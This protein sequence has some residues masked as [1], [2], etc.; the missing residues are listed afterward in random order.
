MLNMENDLPGD[1]ALFFPEDGSMVTD[2]TPT[3]M[4]EEPDDQDDAIASF[5]NQI[6]SLGVNSQSQNRE[7]THY[8][9]K[10]IMQ[11]A[12]TVNSRSIEGYDVFISPNILFTDIEPVHVDSNSYTI[13]TNLIEDLEYY[14]KV[15]AI[16]DDGGQTESEVFSFW[17]N[18][19]NSPP[20]EITLL[21]PERESI[22]GTRPLFSWSESSD[23]DLNDDVNYTFVYGDDVTSLVYVEV[24]DQL[25]HF[26]SDSLL[27]NTE[28]FWQ[29]IAED[30]S[31]A[32]YT[33]PLQSFFVNAENDNPE[34]FALL[35]PDS[36]SVVQ[37]FDQYLIWLPSTDLDGDTVEYE[38]FIDNQSIGVTNHNYMEVRDLMD[39]VTY[40]W[41]VIASDGIGGVATSATWFFTVNAEN[42]PPSEFSL[43]LPSDEALFTSTGITFN[44]QRS[45]DVDIYDSVAYSL[46]IQSEDTNMVIETGDTSLFIEDF[47]DNQIYHWSVVAYDLNSG[48]TN[49]TGGSRMFI[50]N[51]MNDTPSIVGLMAPN[52]GSTQSD[53]TPNFAWTNSYDPD[54]LDAVSYNLSWWEPFSTDIQSVQ[55]DS[56]G[57]TPNGYLMDNAI[58]QWRIKSEDLSGA[59]SFSDTAYFYTDAYA[60]PPVN[61]ST[62]APAPDA[63]MSSTVVNF[64]WFST[65]DP[66]PNEL[67]KYRIA[68]ST[69][70]SDTSAYVYTAEIEDTSMSI[71]LNNNLQYFW[72]AQA[73]DKDNFVVSS[74]YNTPNTFIIGTLST[75]EDL[76]PNV[77]ALHQNFPNP[78]NPTTTIRYDLPNEE[79]VSIVIFDVVGRKIRSLINQ[80]QSAG[81][82]R[83]QWDA[84]NDLG[85]PVSA[86]MY[87]Y[88]LHAGDHRSVKKMVLL[89]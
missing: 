53:L 40:E 23:D 3:L 71:L 17:T 30:Y 41:Y 10:V 70:W 59:A 7:K 44:W 58:Y 78:F 81:Y 48:T 46:H 61:F 14:W 86:G 27:D 75:E 89:K 66:D 36:G 20:A 49:N 85:E 68:Y 38:V 12:A 83:I 24:D 52:E 87:I 74:N 56:N 18:N 22:T 67:I 28:Y 79:D 26:T 13:D 60:E 54:P 19:Q 1:F 21:T 69:D 32:T 42:N 5:G 8:F 39:D 29:V 63:N 43:L 82:H 9:F 33:T 35:S 76:I 11:E 55:I 45:F 77:F 4:W 2:L 62:I 72:V 51:L 15:V 34:G 88:I 50:V 31:G 47:A 25:S 16:D 84:K 6:F 64:K 80:N 57:F 73:I 37:G 65:I